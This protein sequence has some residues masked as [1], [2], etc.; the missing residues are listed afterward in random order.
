MTRGF[1]MQAKR[2]AE[3]I[4]EGDDVARF[5]ITVTNQTVRGRTSKSSKVVAGSKT[6]TK[7]GAV[8]V[9]RNRI[10]RRLREALRQAGPK[11]AQVGVDYVLIGRKVAL[12]LDYEILIKDL[13]KSFQNI[14]RKLIP[15]DKD[16][17]KSCTS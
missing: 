12:T 13:E 4:P 1:V 10:R 3:V 11:H 16:K 6:D 9:M 2:R 7:R 8:S 14:H 15:T 17:A 5:G